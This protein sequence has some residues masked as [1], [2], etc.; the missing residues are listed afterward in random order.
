MVKLEYTVAESFREINQNRSTY[1][2]RVPYHRKSRVPSSTVRVCLPP[3]YRVLELQ[4][5]IQEEEEEVKG[6][7]GVQSEAQPQPYN[8]VAIRGESSQRT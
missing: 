7:G 8:T 2:K 1:C 4:S 5:T 6:G 3:I